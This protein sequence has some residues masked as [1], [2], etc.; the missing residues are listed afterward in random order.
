M[1]VLEHV[2]N[3]GTFIEAVSKNVKPGGWVFMSTMSKTWES[4]LKL[5]VGAEYIGGI[6]KIGTHDWNSFIN[7]ENL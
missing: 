1:E 6:V 3:K 7:P 5:I 2:N 4:Y